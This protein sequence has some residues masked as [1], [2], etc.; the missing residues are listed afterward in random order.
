[1]KTDSI[2]GAYN[3]VLPQVMRTLTDKV[4][5]FNW[6]RVQSTGHP[7]YEHFNYRVKSEDSMREKCTRRGLP[8]TPESALLE[9]KDSIGLRIITNFV[10]D[11]Y[12]TAAFIRDLPNVTVITEKDYIKNVKPNGYRSYHMI[13]QLEAP[14]EDI[15]GNNPGRW[16]A[17]V[18][19]RTIAMD[20]WAAL[21]HEMK[22]KKSIA[23]SRMIESELK[24][25]ADELAS[26]DVSM[27]TIR[28]LIREDEN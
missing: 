7:I 1:M 13:L 26:C 21:E 17:E 24:R 19:L 14:Y 12:K 28:D 10:D 20:S 23:N 9:L 16:Y 5:Q 2:Y 6:E 15:M 8:Q 22:Y 11:I 27:Q 4:I 3:E 18:Q 25:V